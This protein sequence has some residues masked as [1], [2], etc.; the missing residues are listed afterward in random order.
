MYE[1]RNICGFCFYL[2]VPTG[3]IISSNILALGYSLIK[4]RPHF[5][6][7]FLLERKWVYK[8]LYL[9]FC[10]LTICLQRLVSSSPFSNAIRFAYFKWSRPPVMFLIFS[11]TSCFLCVRTYLYYIY[12]HNNRIDKKFNTDSVGSRCNVFYVYNKFSLQVFHLISILML[13]TTLLTSIMAKK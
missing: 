9:L 12:P 3:Y 8:S 2:V 13:Y 1:D 10:K 4:S 7:G 11:N 6:W 5:L